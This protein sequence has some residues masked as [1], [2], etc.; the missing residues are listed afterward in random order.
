M[1]KIIRNIIAGILGFFIK[2]TGEF[3]DAVNLAKSGNC[4][5]ALCFHNP[6]EKLFT[7]CINWLLDNGFYFVS[8]SDVFDFVYNKRSLPGG[9]V[10]ISFDDG[11]KGN[12]KNVLPVLVQKK[13][14]ATFFICTGS[15][16]DKG[17][18][19][20]TLF[21]KHKKHLPEP[22]NRDINKLWDVNET[23]RKKIANLMEEKFGSGMVREAMTVEDVRSMSKYD[24]ISFGSHT[25]N[26]VIT[27]N[28][29]PEVVDRELR[30]SKEKIEKWTGKPSVS[31]CFPNGDYT[32]KEDEFLLKNGYRLAVIGGN[33]FIRSK[34]YVLRLRRFGI[35]NGFFQEELCHI[36]GV[37]QQKVLKI[38]NIAK[39]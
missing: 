34:D 9:A 10:W 36:F 35:G 22:Y 32:G 14:P 29:S 16:Q 27:P 19:W 1:L 4:I 21:E 7:K 17:Y 5:T 30:E 2:F 11:W 39:K 6:S 12:I 18:F 25:V 37:W 31:F 28:C 13:I 23:E 20:W 15:V 3:S 38:K 26:H 33:D 24:F 8:E